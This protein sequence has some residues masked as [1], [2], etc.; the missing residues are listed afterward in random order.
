MNPKP[1][2]NKDQKEKDKIKSLEQE[3]N[4]IKSRLRQN[5]NKTRS[6]YLEE[7]PDKKPKPKENEIILSEKE[8]CRK[9]LEEI[10]NDEK[11][12]LFRQPAIKAF[13]DKEGKDYYRKQIKEPRDL[14]NITKKL[15]STKYTAKEF[16]DDLELCWTNATT[17]NDANTEAYQCAVYLKDLS[18]SLYKKYGLFDFINKS[19]ENKDDIKNNETNVNVNDNNNSSINNSINNNIKNIGEQSDENKNVINNILINEENKIE[20]KENNDISNNDK[21]NEIIIDNN[22]TKENNNKDTTKEN[23]NINT[24]NN[25]TSNNNNKIIG[26][27]RKRNDD[28]TELIESKEKKVEKKKEIINYTYSDIKNKFIIKH[29]MLTCPS[30]IPKLFKKSF[31]K[32]KKRT[33]VKKTEKQNIKNE[34]HIHHTKIQHLL[35]INKDKDKR[36]IITEKDF[37]RKINFEWNKF[38][39][40]INNKNNKEEVEIDISIGA[41]ENNMGENGEENNK[42][43]INMNI[44]EMIKLEKEQMSKND[45]N[46]NTENV[47][48]L[49]IK[50][51]FNKKSMMKD[52]DK[53][54]NS[55]NNQYNLYNIGN[56]KT[57]MN[58]PNHINNHRNT[59]KKNDKY[60]ALRN[61]IAKYFDKL[62]DNIMIELLVF[63]E[64]IRPQSIKELA[65]DTIY[66]NM[67]L[68][69]DE[70]FNKVLEFVKKFEQ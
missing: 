50:K 9:I 61:E 29:P 31:I 8:V 7:Y 41:S 46:Y 66:I 33:K 47:F 11:S 65:N 39:N 58:D 37:P 35:Y 30:D 36:Q 3:S 27:K 49:N 1:K 56:I 5:P 22:K 38:N 17:F 44:D 28:I 40:N 4:N 53:I 64:N 21:T 42:N 57:N 67:E 32:R 68:F 55:I 18:D 23:K 12:I 52:L 2:N 45:F 16:H 26:K 62:N 15:K 24:T 51:D 19:K 13:N 43:K 20:N 59:N 69:N 6:L 48:D 60:F 25:N 63:I 34:T 54:N 10:K 14:G 70:T